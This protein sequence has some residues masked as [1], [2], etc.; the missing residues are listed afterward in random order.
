MLCVSHKD[1]LQCAVSP[2]CGGMPSKPFS[3]KYRAMYFDNHHAS[4]KSVSLLVFWHVVNTLGCLKEKSVVNI[5]KMTLFL[6]SHTS[7]NCWVWKFNLSP[8]NLQD[9]EHAVSSLVLGRIEFLSVNNFWKACQWLPHSC[10]FIYSLLHLTGQLFVFYSVLLC[11]KWD[12][13]VTS[14]PRGCSELL[15]R[16]LFI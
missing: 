6:L 7:I 4:V 8:M 16:F 11:L 1:L 15:E 12:R 14:M 2:V 3:R 5:W 9:L 10:W 13:P